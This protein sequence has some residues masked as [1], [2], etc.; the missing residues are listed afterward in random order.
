MRG[1][2]CARERGSVSCRHLAVM[3]LVFCVKQHLSQLHAFVIASIGKA[4]QIEI[5]QAGE[6]VLDE[7]S[8]LVCELHAFVCFLC[9]HTPELELCLQILHFVA[10]LLQ[11][12]LKLLDHAP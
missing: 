4:A 7:G 1:E 9:F 8:G 6:A 11:L 5:R 12:L 3:K 2:S 10:Q